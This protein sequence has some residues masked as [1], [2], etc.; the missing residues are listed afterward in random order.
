[1]WS[2]TKY[3]NLANYTPANLDELGEAATDSLI[4]QN[5]DRRTKR[6][7]FQTAKLNL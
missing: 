2:C 4:S 5:G 7:Y 1:M 6:S 3:S